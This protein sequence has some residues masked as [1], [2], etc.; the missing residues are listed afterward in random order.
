MA[1][2]LNNAQRVAGG[3]SYTVPGTSANNRLVVMIGFART[4]S[5]FDVEAIR[6]GAQSATA[7]HS[8]DFVTQ[9][10]DLNGG[11]FYIKE[12]DI[13]SGAQ[14]LNIDFRDVEGDNSLDTNIVASSAIV[15]T[16]Y[17]FDQTATPIDINPT[18]YNVDA[19]G[20]K[21][22]SVNYG[23]N[24]GKF[25]VGVGLSA[26][27]IAEQYTMTNNLGDLVIDGYNSG[28]NG[29]HPTIS[30]NYEVVKIDA[31][32][33]NS[34]STQFT[35]DYASSGTSTA[36]ARMNIGY[37]LVF[38]E[39]AVSPTV[40]INESNLEPGGTISGSYSNF[41]AGTPPTSPLTV[42]DGTNSITVAVT[43]TDN[44]DGTGTFTGTMPSLPAAGNS[45]SFVLFGNVTVTLD[46]A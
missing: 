13:P 41:T 17:D 12:A 39:I 44:G 40:T 20:Q 30:T 29:A 16:L 35:V 5:R 24:S 42:S 6:L 23:A 27:S 22:Y 18:L 34:E 45:A 7:L 15:F 26:G 8:G 14:T 32:A 21:Q 10:N 1:I 11:V 28:D 2:T 3:G 37:A 19:L 31:L 33:S 25:A 46:D 4:N 9:F 36:G 43:V 38:D